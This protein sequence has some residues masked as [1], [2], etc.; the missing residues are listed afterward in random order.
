MTT[1]LGGAG[2]CRRRSAL[3]LI[4]VLVVISI[5]GLLVGLLIPAVQG[6]REA[7]R[8]AKCAN[9]LKQ[10]GI[11]LHA[12]EADRGTL[13][14]GLD[15]Q[16]HSLHIHLLPMLEQTQVYN[17]INFEF[18]SGIDGGVNSTVRTIKLDVF[19][20][21][22]ESR[23]PV[24]GGLPSVGWTNYPGCIGD[25]RGETLRVYDGVFSIGQAPYSSKNITDGLSTTVSMS[26]WLLEVRESTPNV[27]PRRHVLRVQGDHGGV[28]LDYDGFVTACAAPRKRARWFPHQGAMADG[29]VYHA[30]QQHD[31]SQRPKLREARFPG[32]PGGQYYLGERP[33]RRGEH[34]AR[35]RAC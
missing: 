3:T 25:G 11:A 6:A 18:L 29:R 22:S 26:E 30:L 35:G 8:R 32:G 5:I 23:T 14:A 9:N 34:P 15:R 24:A 10:L 21:P 27:D 1:T 4:E 19:A 2:V 31:A 33:S 17:A 28:P 13:P 16:G 20:C 12:F 7:A